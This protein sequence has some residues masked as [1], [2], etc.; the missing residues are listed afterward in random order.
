[1]D[2]R[3]KKHNTKTVNK[4]ILNLTEEHLK[5]G[6][7]ILLD[8]GEKDLLQTNSRCVPVGTISITPDGRNEK[9]S[10][11]RRKTD[12]IKFRCTS[13]EKKLLKNRAKRSGLTLSEY[14]RRVAF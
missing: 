14:L 13:M 7:T 2:L 12:V 11:F 3:T 4:A 1:M 5:D 10:R 8:I 6:D 9:K